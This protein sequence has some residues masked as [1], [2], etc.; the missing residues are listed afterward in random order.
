MRPCVVCGKYDPKPYFLAVHVGANTYDY[1]GS[2]CREC[3]MKGIV[4]VSETDP[5]TEDGT[6][7]SEPEQ[8]V[9]EEQEGGEEPAK[10]EVVTEAYELLRRAFVGN[11]S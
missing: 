7:P 3:A 6:V 4:R 5:E 11:I 10:A 1:G 9:E 2:L 8:P